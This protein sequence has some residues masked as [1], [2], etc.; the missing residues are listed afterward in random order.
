MAKTLTQRARARLGRIRR[1]LGRS[2]LRRV[3]APSPAKPVRGAVRRTDP[4]DHFASLLPNKA[5]RKVAILASGSQRAQVEPWLARFGG[6][7]CHV[8]SPSAA[9]EWSLESTRIIHHRAGTIADQATELKLIGPVDVLV[10]LLDTDHETHMHMWRRFFFHVA[11]D[12]LYVLDRRSQAA[13]TFPNALTN[14]LAALAS[15][16]NPDEPVKLHRPDG[17]YIGS[18][19]GLVVTRDLVIFT[20]RYQHFLKLRHSEANKVLATREPKLKVAVLD[21]KSRG[22]VRS[23]A[24][25]NL[26]ESATAIE[27]ILE[28]IAYPDLFVRHYQGKIAFLGTGVFYTGNSILPDSFRHHLLPTPTCP[29]VKS[30]SPS[31]G[32]IAGGDRPRKSLAG[33]YY[34]LDSAYTAHFGHLTTE[35]LSRLWGW[36][37]AK[38]AIPDLKVIMSMNHENHHD[39]KLERQ[40][41]SAYGIP[42]EDIVTV[43]EPVF[44]ESVVSAT[45]MWHN[46]EPHYVHPGMTEVWARLTE[47]LIDRNAPQY[48]KVFISRTKRWKHRVCRNTDEVERYF[49][50]RGFTVVYP[51]ELDLGQQVAIFAGATTVAGFGGSALFNIMHAPQMKTLIVLSHESYTARNEHLFTALLGTNV[52]YFWSAADVTHPEDAWAIDAFY[53]EWEFDFARNRDALDDVLS[54][55]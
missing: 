40:L 45:P 35:V 14:W 55:V 38:A 30:V 6:E 32:R 31:F 47:R 16:D 17:E 37:S 42:E 10:N 33:N 44:L 43:A 19:G 41:F 3:L 48:D 34:N 8:L 5:N 28:E 4:L 11:K 12:G 22:T 7:D 26:H 49:E 29:K 21:R 20:K 53:S 1:R 52:H 54:R 51:E 50:E 24:M 18:T 25:V 39:P 15:P 2:R 46:A 23:K 36:D 27:H 13:R 9:P